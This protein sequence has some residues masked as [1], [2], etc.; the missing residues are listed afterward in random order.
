MTAVDLP[1]PCDEVRG[2]EANAPPANMSASLPNGV[3]LTLECGDVD[4]RQ[5]HSER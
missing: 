2:P 3:K 5:P 1:A 4:A